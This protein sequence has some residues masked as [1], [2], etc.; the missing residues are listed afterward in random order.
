MKPI[1][2]MPALKDYLWGGTRLKTEFK[3]ESNLEKIA[4]AWVLSC[5]SDGPSLAAEGEFEGKALA[6]IIDEL[7]ADCLGTRG[8]EYPFF[9]IL[10]KLIDAKAPLS[11]QVHP[12]DEYAL[13][14]ENQ[15]GKTEMWY[16]VDCDEGASL[17]YGFSREISREEFRERIENDTLL[18]VLNRV[19]VKKGDCFFIDS[20][21]IHAIGEGILIAEIQ[22]NSNCTYRVYDYGRVGADGKPR[23]LHIEKALAVTKTAPPEYPFGKPESDMLASC[24]YFTVTRHSLMGEKELSVGSDSFAA[25]LCTEGECEI[26][27]V[28]LR[29]GE[30]A[31]VPAYYGKVK[32]CGKGEVLESRV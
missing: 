26:D 3:I 27:G 20:G 5:H 31:F 32:L 17:Y 2:L 14:N 15:F 28:L 25:F 6:E 12:S 23:E 29:A 30:C 19:P 8:G 7:G 22:Q 11:I 21:T 4:E 1:K 24:K 10:I 13:E 16:I 9:P 18:E